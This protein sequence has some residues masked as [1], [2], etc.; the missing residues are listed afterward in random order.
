M[1]LISQGCSV[2]IQVL[3]AV[4]LATPALA[5]IVKINLLQLNDIYEI[6]PV[7]GGTRGGLARVATLRQQLY[8]ANPRT[9]TVLAGDTFSPS[10]LGTAKINGTPLAGQQMVAV[11]NALGLNYATFGN[12]EFDLPENLFYQRLE[13][14]QFRWVSSNVSDSTGQPFKGVPR[15]IVFNVKGDRGAVVRVGLIG[16]T[17]DSNKPKY[18]SYTDPITTA[19]QQVSTLKGKVDIIVA[20]THQ[21]I[22][23]DRKLAE[24][25][26]EIDIILGGH[27]HEN[28]QQWRGQD[29][30]PIFKADANARTVYVHQLNYDTINRSLVI[31]SR[32]VPITDKIPDEPR[33]AKIVEEW[34]ER[35]YQA[36]RANGFEPNQV[37]AKLSF[38]LDGL[39]SSV[40]NKSTN[41]TELV[42]LAMLQEVPDADLA[43]FNGGSIRI[44]DILPPGAITQYD[45]IRILPFGGKVVAVEISGALLQ[46]VL[47]QGQ[48]NKGTGGYLQTAK[49]S[50][51][52]NS[53][54]WLIQGQPLD[55]N[56]TYKIAISDF[57]ISGKEKGLDFLNLQQSGIKLIAE[58]RDIRFVVIDQLK[59]QAT[60]SQIL[61]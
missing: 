44:D 50:Q 22:E 12:H 60:A 4:T 17:L 37:I 43:V 20:I 3:V 54:S 5:E 49:V 1:K 28:T 61:K 30:T 46:R 55:P 48:A 39:E 25:V 29:F 57:L 51:Q 2:V 6:T 35:G 33:T 31:N 24:T 36:F 15:S 38:A 27:E 7:E 56:R 11:M 41:L 16:V 26:P 13:E 18:V 32:L 42:A 14:S 8:K 10:A 45:V 19:K 52:A 34:V 47:D 59:R 53:R 58:K 21:S 23:D 40:R 9:Y